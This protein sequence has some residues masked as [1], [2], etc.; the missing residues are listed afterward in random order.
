MGVVAI[1]QQALH[2]IWAMRRNRRRYFANSLGQAAGHL[3]VCAWQK[4]A[5]FFKER[6][7][8]P[9]EFAISTK[10]PHLIWAQ[11]DDLSV[12]ADNDEAGFRVVEYGKSRNVVLPDSLKREIQGTKLQRELRRRGIGQHTIEK[13]LHAHVRVKDLQENCGSRGR[14]QEREQQVSRCHRVVQSVNGRKRT[15]IYAL[16]EFGRQDDGSCQHRE[17]RNARRRQSRSERHS[18]KLIIVLGKEAFPK[19]K[20]CHIPVAALDAKKRVTPIA[21]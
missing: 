16:Y 21:S 12:V 4:L 19:T 8:Q 15:I 9:E 1:F 5:D 11:G 6:T 7:S 13:A 3:T 17:I 14:I 10:R 2:V 18:M 20:D